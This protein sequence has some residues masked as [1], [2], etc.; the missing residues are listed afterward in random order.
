MFKRIHILTILATVAAFTSCV[1]EMEAPVEYSSVQVELIQ[2]PSAQTKSTVTASETA[3]NNVTFVIFDHGTGQLQDAVHFASAASMK[4][5]KK[6]MKGKTYDIWAVANVGDISQTVRSSYASAASFLSSFACTFASFG[7]VTASGVPMASAAPATVTPT[8]AANES[9]Q[10]S[11][12]RL[13]AKYIVNIDRSALNTGS[14]LTVK[15]LA[16]RQAALTMMPF[17]QEGDRKTTNVSSGDY[18]T[19]A[20]ITALNNGNIATFYI[21]ENRQGVLLPGNTD[22]WGKIPGTAALKGACTY[23]EMVC[24][25]AKTDKT[26]DNVTYRMYLGSN[27]TTDFSVTRNTTYTLTLKPTDAGL[28]QSS[29]KLDPGEIITYTHEVKVE[30]AEPTIKWHETQAFTAKYYTYKYVDGAIDPSSTTFTDITTTASWSS[31]DPAIATMSGATATALAKGTSTV[32][33]TYTV[34][35]TGA[36][37]SG[38]ATLTVE[39][40]ITYRD[41]IEITGP[42]TIEKGETADYVATKKTYRYVNDE[43]DAEPTST[44][45]VTGTATWS[46]GDTSVATVSGGSITGMNVGQVTITASTGTGDS[47]VTGTKTITVENKVTYEYELEISPATAGIKVGGTQAFTAKFMTYKCINGVRQ[48]PA[49][50]STDVT[51]TYTSKNASVATVSGATATGVGQGTATIEATYTDPVHSVTVTDTATLTVENNVTYEYELELTPATASVVVGGTQTYTATLV[52]YECING[53]RQTPAKS[54]T[55]VPATVTSK[56]TSVA[57]VS[58]S[59]ATGVGKGTATIEASYTVP[60]TTTT[61][62]KTS[63]LT[64]DDNVSSVTLIEV[65]GADVVSYGTP[66]SLTARKNTY[67]VVNGVRESTPTTSVDVTTS[68]SWSSGN[69]GVATVGASTGVVSAVNKGSAVI[70][71]TDGTLSGSKTV[72]VND[73]VTKTHSL[74]VTPATA[75]I[76][77]NATQAFTATY[78]TYTLVNGSEKVDERDSDDVSALAAWSSPDAAKVSFSG[79]TAT[80][81]VPGTYTVS[82]TYSGEQDTASLKVEDYIVSYEN[83]VITAFTY[84]PATIPAAGGYATPKTV[85]YSQKVNWA[86]GPPTTITSGGTVSY[87]GAATGFKLDTSTGKVTATSKNTGEP[88]SITVTA[89]VTLNGKTGTKTAAVIQEADLEII[90]E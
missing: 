34:P 70:T 83:P 58:G 74:E 79:A 80:G 53:V 86:Y 47:K 27:A 77:V 45:T 4:L 21:P 33:A 38:T 36:S 69:T 71:A 32:K 44:A 50:S 67:K 20:D 9:F 23:L 63:T 30:P 6:L 15:S 78:Y 60:G 18:A 19:A 65:S 57:T 51:A 56:N 48:T 26:A 1:K 28:D 3:V 72:T 59:T 5:E 2:E 49:E 55:T 81:K 88:R 16:I 35:G 24:S 85:E 82:A 90:L 42:A 84:D 68:V 43:K 40:K 13:L 62:T 75:T 52:T 31:S 14:T 73:V 12:E 29:W 87:S 25:Y 41:E 8:G 7:A 37:V 61:V 11:V 66:V 54:T 76:K 89:S 39:D 22:P 64:V 10:I 46:S 17:A